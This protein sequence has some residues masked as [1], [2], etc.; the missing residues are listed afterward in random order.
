M[1]SNIRIIL[2]DFFRKHTSIYW[3]FC[4][5]G[6]PTIIHGRKTYVDDPVYLGR[7]VRDF[8]PKGLS[9]VREVR[10]ILRELEED[11]K[12]GISSRIIQGRI[13]ILFLA[14]LHTTLMSKSEKIEVEWI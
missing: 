14:V 10:G 11:Y 5:V 3:G 1:N 7:Q 4:L 6:K 8:S 13:Y 12:H 2:I 9:D